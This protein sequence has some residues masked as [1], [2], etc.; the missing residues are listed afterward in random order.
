MKQRLRLPEKGQISKR[1]ITRRRASVEKKAGSQR[2][3]NRRIPTLRLLLNAE[4]L[5]G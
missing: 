1:E 2:N 4:E 3:K 5:T